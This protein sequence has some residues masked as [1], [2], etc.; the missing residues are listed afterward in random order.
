MIYCLYST[1]KLLKTSI[2]YAI[3]ISIS[4]KGD[5]EL[6]GFNEQVVKRVNK[7]AQ[8]V[9]KILS[10]VLLITVPIV[11]VL[12]ANIIP[13]MVFVG[14]FLF[15]GGIYIVWYVVTSQRVEFEYSVSGDELDISKI[16]SL[17][18]RKRICKVPIREIEKLEKGEKSIEG[19]KFLKCFQAAHDIDKDEENYYAVFNSPAYG[20]SLLI[21][22]P[23]EQILEGMKKYLNKDIVLK[24]FYKRNAS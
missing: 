21:F 6:E 13:Y 18:K 16:I 22:T 15:I 17:R 23:N 2:Y 20:K 12:L 19:I 14:L 7:T 1:T 11:C 8:L 3:I 24:L 10:F 4:A 9:I 5:L